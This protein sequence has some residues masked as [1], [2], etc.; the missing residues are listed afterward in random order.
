MRIRARFLLPAAFALLAAFPPPRLLADVGRWTNSG[1]DGG[2]VLTIASHPSNP[3]IVYAA[4]SQGLYKSVDAG[5]FWTLLLSG[6]FGHVIPT[7]DPSVVY[8]TSRSG[9]TIF[10]TTDGAENWAEF[11]SQGPIYGVT[12]EPD[13][14]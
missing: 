10:R 9:G 11:G 7:S 5:G 3:S 4:T 6:A 1:P 14:P 2:S 8:A 12:V 13:D